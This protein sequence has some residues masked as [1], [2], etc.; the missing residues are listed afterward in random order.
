MQ[1]NYTIHQV[2][3]AMDILFKDA[4]TLQP[5]Y[6]NIIKTAMHTVTPENIANFLGK[7]FS[8]LFEG[9][10]GSSCNKRILGTRSANEVC[11]NT[12]WVKCR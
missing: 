4:A 5:V 8:V 2:E 9:E 12:R 7:R 10:A 1:F 6:E 11:E 3:Y